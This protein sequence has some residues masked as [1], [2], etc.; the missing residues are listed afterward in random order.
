MAREYK[1]PCPRENKARRPQEGKKQQPE[2]EQE[3]RKPASL[4]AAGG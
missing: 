2:K 3:G 1:A 4:G